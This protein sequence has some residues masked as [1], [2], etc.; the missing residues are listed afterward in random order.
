M[1]LNLRI[2]TDL[3]DISTNKCVNTDWIL[4]QT[5]GKTKKRDNQRHL[6]AAWK[7]DNIKEILVYLK[8]DNTYY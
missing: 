5:K 2:K 4:I 7:F 8:C 3:K 1:W 6:N